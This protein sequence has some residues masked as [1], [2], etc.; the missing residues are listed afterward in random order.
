MAVKAQL[1]V[2]MG[3]GLISK[4]IIEINLI[5]KS[6]E[7]CYRESCYRKTLSTSFK[8]LSE[9]CGG[10]MG[11]TL[12]HVVVGINSNSP[13]FVKVLRFYDGEFGSRGGSPYSRR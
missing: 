1:C 2:F 7:T 11:R 6:D 5:I 12:F 8:I 13:S 3:N 9:S 4:L 10:L